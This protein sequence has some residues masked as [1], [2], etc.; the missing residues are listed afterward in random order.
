MQLCLTLEHRFFQTPDQKIWTVT[1][2]PYDFY[3]EYL[4]VFDS[5][6]VISRAF[7]V[8]RAESNF[9]PVE[10][11]GVEFYAM[12]GY[13]G[14][15]QFLGQF[16]NVRQKAKSAVSAGS[17]VIFRLPSQVGNSVEAWL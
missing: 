17:A 12:P 4:Q 13:K 16:A 7:P 14:P 3:R 2:C 1:Q 5:V 11:P 9:L 6:R 15:F 10:G 8:A